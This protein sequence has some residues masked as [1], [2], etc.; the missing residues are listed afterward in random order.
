[1]G[2]GVDLLAAFLTVVARAAFGLAVC[3]TAGFAIF[4]AEVLTAFAEV[5]VTL[6]AVDCLV[7]FFAGIESYLL[8]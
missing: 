4:L 1:L 2:V 3:F 5:V 8:I 7:F 6:V